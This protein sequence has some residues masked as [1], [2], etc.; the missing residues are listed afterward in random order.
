MSDLRKLARGRECQIRIPGRCNGMPE[1][2]VLCHYRLPG[3][4]SGLGMKS[5]DWCGAWGCS[6]CHSVVDG[7]RGSWVEFPREFRDL[8]LLSGVI[9][10]L[11]ILIDEGVIVVA[12]K[13][14]KPSKVFRRQA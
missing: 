7:Q 11:A 14:P 3:V 13:S 12:G 5:A 2:V 8:L 6:D 4:L 1:T 10:T 9:R